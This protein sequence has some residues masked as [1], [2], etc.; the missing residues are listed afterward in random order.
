MK[1]VAR[2]SPAG[3]IVFV[4]NMQK[5]P[6]TATLQSGQTLNLDPLEIAPLLVDTTLAPASARSSVRCGPWGSPRTGRRRLGSSTASR[7]K[8]ATSNS[9]STYLPRA[10]SAARTTTSAFKVNAAADARHPVIDLAFSEAAPQELIFT[11]GG[12]TLRILAE[13]PAWTDRTWIVGLRGAQSVVTGPDYV[14]DF[15]ETNG[16]AQLTVARPFGHP[17][18]NGIVIYGEG[19]SRNIAVTDPAPADVDTAPALGTWEM[20]Q[21]RCPPRHPIIPTRAGWPAIPHP[22]SA[23][24]A[25]PRLMAGTALRSTHPP[26][27]PAKL[28]GEFAN[29]AVIFLNGAPA[30]LTYWKKGLTLNVKSGRNTLAVFISQSGRQKAFNYVNKPLDTY[31]PKGILGPVTVTIGSQVIP[32]TGWKLRGGISEPDAPDLAWQPAPAGNTGVPSFFRTQFD[33]KA[34]TA[35]G[36]QPIYR[37]STH[38]LSHGNVWL[39]GHNLGR[40]QENL[41]IDGPLSA[42]VLA[43]GRSELAGDL[44]RGGAC[45]RPGRSI[46]GVNG[47]P[48]ARSF[49]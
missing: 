43:E 21:S 25:I 37:L 5:T 46:S 6:E 32:V 7:R 34:A 44:R 30:G 11:A 19:K 48:A 47:P 12:K 20:A 42:R 16:K 49:R 23:P 15:S 28:N 26:D 27:G 39:N 8:R 35:T 2:T 1:P 24:T 41:K 10:D 36:P 14:G 18:L 40:Y 17:A 3:T 9:I 31:D 4:R 13:T 33:A 45:P 29:R 22:N 38:G